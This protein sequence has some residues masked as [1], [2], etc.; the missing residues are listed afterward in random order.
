[1]DVN[2]AKTNFFGTL[3]LHN[4]QE[5]VLR[6][7][8]MNGSASV[9]HLEQI[10]SAYPTQHIVLFW[11]R[12]TWHKGEV[13]R[14]FLKDHE[15]LEVI[16]FPV[17]SPEMNPQEHVWKATRNAVSHNHLPEK[18]D[19]V[20]DQFEGHLRQSSFESSFLFHYGFDAIHCATF[21]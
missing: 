4:G 6:A 17:S 16:Y 8:Q 3:N 12:A 11:D 21:R 18:L 15:R 9:Q 14:N 10:L 20:A 7:E 13:V 1:M 5:L 19:K 2:R